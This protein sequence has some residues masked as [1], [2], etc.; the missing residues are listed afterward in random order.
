[1]LHDMFAVPFVEIAR[2][3]GQPPDATK[4]MASRA[5]RRAVV[6]SIINIEKFTGR[7]PI[8]MAKS[9]AGNDYYAVPAVRGCLPRV[10]DRG[11]REDPGWHVHLAVRDQPQVRGHLGHD[12][13]QRGRPGAAA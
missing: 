2:L 12:R 8:L 1:V 13:R 7:L 5:R 4:M 10:L 11:Q 9:R 6:V 3:L